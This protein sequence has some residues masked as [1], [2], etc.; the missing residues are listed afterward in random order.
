MI[1]HPLNTVAFITPVW[2]CEHGEHVLEIAISYVSRG[3]DKPLLFANHKPCRLVHTGVSDKK[4]AGLDGAA[5]FCRDDLLGT[6][7]AADATSVCTVPGSW[8][9]AG[10]RLFSRPSAQAATMHKQSTH[11]VNATHPKSL[12]DPLHSL[13]EVQHA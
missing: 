7:I 12:W 10:S 4:H 2:H 3:D 13:A 8:G 6:S 5:D 11:A 1:P 9:C